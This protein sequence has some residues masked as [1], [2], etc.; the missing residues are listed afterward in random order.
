MAGMAFDFDERIMNQTRIVLAACKDVSG[1]E[2]CQAI[3]NIV[4]C[5][6]K[7]AKQNKFPEDFF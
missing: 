7:V 5:A 4:R 3:D 2:R 6:R 1:P